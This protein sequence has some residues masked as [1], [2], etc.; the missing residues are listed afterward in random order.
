MAKRKAQWNT[1]R[2]CALCPTRYTPT[3]PSQRYCLGCRGEAGL[4]RMRK[5]RAA[6]SHWRRPRTCEGCHAAF[7]PEYASQKYCSHC[8]EW[9]R[10]AVH[11]RYRHSQK[12][13][14]HQDSYNRSQLGRRAHYRY[15]K[16]KKAKLTRSIYN[17]ARYQ[18]KKAA[19]RA[20]VAADSVQAAADSA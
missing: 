16:S 10:L 5:Y 2:V 15:V 13:K 1:P 20:A 18:A 19:A 8:K 17:K 7:L 9:A 6:K 14:V 3:S 4:A 12:G 11:R